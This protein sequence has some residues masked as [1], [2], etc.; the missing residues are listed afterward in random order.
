M[1]NARGQLGGV[2]RQVWDTDASLSFPP[3]RIVSDRLSSYSALFLWENYG[4][5]GFLAETPESMC[6]IIGHFDA[7]AFFEGSQLQVR[8]EHYAS[9]K[10]APHLSVRWERGWRGRLC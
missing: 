4:S 5:R 10:E 1:D 3:Y 9:S 8:Q 7:P 6:R 2:K